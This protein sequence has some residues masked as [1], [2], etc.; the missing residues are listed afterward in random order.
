FPDL[1]DSA[2]EWCRLHPDRA[3]ALKL[4]APKGED[5]GNYTNRL[6][7]LVQHISQKA[8]RSRFLGF[9][10]EWDAGLPPRTISLLADL[11][12]EGSR[13]N[14][15]CGIEPNQSF[16]AS[17]DPDA[18]IR[19][20]QMVSDLILDRDIN[21]FFLPAASVR[22]ARYP[23][24]ELNPLWL[25]L[26]SREKRVFPADT[27]SPEAK[28]STAQF[29]NLPSDPFWNRDEFYFSILRREVAAA[30]ISGFPS[31]PKAVESVLE[32]LLAAFPLKKETKTREKIRAK[33]LLSFGLAQRYDAQVEVAFV[34]NGEWSD[35]LSIASTA[36]NQ[37]ALNRAGLSWRA[38][39]S[40]DTPTPP[41][42]FFKSP[43]SENLGRMILE[44]ISARTNEQTFIITGYSNLSDEPLVKNIQINNLN[45]FLVSRPYLNPD[46]LNQIYRACGLRP[47]LSTGDEILAQGPWI[48]LHTRESGTKECQ[49]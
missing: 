35:T 15:I 14:Q 31:E 42:L 9:V 45:F 33:E 25:Q 7:L 22:T 18:K 1:D 47:F 5:P 17:T 34:I 44:K 10:F 21:S 40:E 4:P 28:S 39:M 20:F 23:D 24:Q 30:V 38:C 16:T 36:S 13:Q 37:R 26:L 2:E 46:E 11:V 27:A 3:F 29:P 12:K 8:Y 32:E 41:V 49:P 19:H 6:R 48:L 43:P